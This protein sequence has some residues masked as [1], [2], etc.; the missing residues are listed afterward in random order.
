SNAA[1]LTVSA[2]PV[3]P[4]I[5]AQPTSQT[6]TAGQTAT[7]SVT[8]TGTAPLS[9]QWRKSGTPITG[10]TSSSYTTPAETTADTGAQFTVA[11]SN[12]AGSVTSSAAILTVNAATLVL[13]VSP[14]SLS[15]GSIDTDAN[16]TLSATLT[17]SGNSNVTISGVGT[18]GAGFSANNV[19]SGTILAP[20]QSAVLNVTFAPTATGSVTGGVTVASN[21]TNSPATISM[22]GIG[23]QSNFSTWVSSSLNRVGKTD[24]PGTLSSIA[25]TG[26]R[27]E[28]V[29]TQV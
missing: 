29:D 17:N 20:G 25:L 24:V 14:T 19:S 8:A 9:Y 22:T 28:T 11:V 10:A 4:S 13:N 27:G 6:I 3:A 23:V 12:T 7:F 26:A 18:S 5:T 21:A 2:A 1:I 15:F 16:S